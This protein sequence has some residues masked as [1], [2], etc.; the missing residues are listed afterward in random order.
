MLRTTRISEQEATPVMS[1]DTTSGIT[2]MRIALTQRVP[3]GSTKSTNFRSA[4]AGSARMARPRISPKTSATR[5]RMVRDMSYRLRHLTHRRLQVPRQKCRSFTN[6]PACGLRG[7]LNVNRVN[8][9][10]RHRLVL[11]A[12]L[13][14]GYLV[15]DVLAFHYF[16]KDGVIARKPRCGGD[17]DKKLAAVGPGTGIRHGQLACFIKFIR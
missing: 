17:G 10:R 5:T 8:H 14:L 16:T 9:H 11:C 3:I 6:Y 1:R 15:C 4:G 7:P 2:V 12:S 13:Y